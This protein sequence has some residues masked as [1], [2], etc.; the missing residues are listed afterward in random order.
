MPY[1]IGCLKYDSSGLIP[2]NELP[3]T[4]PGSG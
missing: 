2:S 4:E 1:Q 3:F